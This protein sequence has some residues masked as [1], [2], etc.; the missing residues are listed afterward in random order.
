MIKTCR[1]KEKDEHLPCGK[2]AVDM[3]LRKLDKEPDVVKNCPGIEDTLGDMADAGFGKNLSQKLKDH[4][5]AS[6]KQDGCRS[7]INKFMGEIDKCD[8]LA[9][10]CLNLLEIKWGVE[11]TKNGKCSYGKN[12][13]SSYAYGERTHLKT[14]AGSSDKD[15]GDKCGIIVAE[16]KTQINNCASKKDPA[17]RLNCSNDIKQKFDKKSKELSGC[18]G[19]EDEIRVYAQLLLH[20]DKGPT[21]SETSAGSSVKDSGDKCG[22]IVAELKTQIN[23][24]ASKKGLEKKKCL[25][26]IKEE[27]DKKSSSTSGCGDFGD[28]LGE[29]AKSNGLPDPDKGPLPK[30]TKPATHGEIPL[31]KG[32]KKCG[33]FISWMKT[34]VSFCM[35]KTGDRREKCKNGSLGSIGVEAG[36]KNFSQGECPGQWDSYENLLDK[37]E[38]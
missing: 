4:R 36:K 2:S 24:C 26:D 23:N 38:E 34:A 11:L 3:F 7:I 21:H 30:I 33:K 31:V 6:V 29:Y 37:L 14:S 13:L 27:F 5:Q 32:G 12:D 9:K 1:K 17:M 8:K 35:K 15:S 22:I 28:K 25:N 10:D 19:L 16:L 18:Q 20:P